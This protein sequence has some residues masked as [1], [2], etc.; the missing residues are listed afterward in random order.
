M[1]EIGLFS[2]GYLAL[3]EIG[4]SLFKTLVDRYE[5]E[6]LGAYRA[7]VFHNTIWF[8][9][10]ARPVRTEALNSYA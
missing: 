10:L 3:I 8:V 6:R 7:R 5:Y 2:S 4:I 1:F 9:K